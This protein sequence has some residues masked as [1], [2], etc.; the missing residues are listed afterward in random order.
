M[1]PGAQQNVQNWQDQLSKLTSGQQNNANMYSGN[2]INPGQQDFQK[3][4]QDH[5]QQFLTTSGQGTAPTPEQQAQA[6]N[7]VDQTFTNP[8]QNALNQYNSDF[9]DAQN[10]KAA[11]LGRNPNAD[12]A[13][14][15]AIYG[16]GLRNTLNL[17]A[18]RGSRIAQTAQDLN[19]QNFQRQYTG[20]MGGTY[21]NNALNQNSAFL[22]DLQQ[23]AFGNQLGLLNSR[24]A[25]GGLLQNQSQRQRETGPGQAGILPQINSLGSQIGGLGG[26]YGSASNGLSSLTGQMGGGGAAASGGGGS[27]GLGLLAMA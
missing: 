22:S 8:T 21:G 14:Q 17:Q 20:I 5:L 2:V 1:T 4:F 27:A 6:A 18:D 26:S 19:S 25:L 7:F 10:A 12:V 9:G 24:S 23:K 13:T 15:Q 11:S 3:M 16:E